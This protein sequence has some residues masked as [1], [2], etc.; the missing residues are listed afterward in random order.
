VLIT[1]E[2]FNGNKISLKNTN[3]YNY[4]NFRILCTVM[5][6][7]WSAKILEI[8]SIYLEM[9]QIESAEIVLI[10]SLNRLFPRDFRGWGNTSN[11]SKKCPE[12]LFRQSQILILLGHIFTRNSFGERPVVWGTRYYC[13]YHL[14]TLV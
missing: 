13:T 1:A 5:V 6:L 14:L 9:L 2:F 4:C 8:L 7:Q 12:P 10:N 11:L 3:F